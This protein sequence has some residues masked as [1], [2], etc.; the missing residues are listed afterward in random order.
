MK[1]YI[2]Y[3]KYYLKTKNY[4]LKPLTK[5]SSY[6]YEFGLKTIAR[7]YLCIGFL[8]AGHSPW[9]IESHNGQLSLKRKK[10]MSKANLYLYWLKTGVM[11]SFIIIK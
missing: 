7:G 8:V 2:K 1:K 4:Y 9:H 5:T 3:I 11:H 6:I 10:H